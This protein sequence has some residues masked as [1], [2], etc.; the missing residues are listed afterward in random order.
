MKP[1]SRTAMRLLIEEVRA[2]LPFDVPRAQVCAG[3][4]DG[5]SLKLLNFLDTELADWERRL[6]AGER[7]NLGAV[8]HLARTSRKV[9]AVLERNGLVGDAAAGLEQAPRVHPDGPN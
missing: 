3:A 5:C 9:Y 7:P 4:C 2:A 6:A 1:D 8:S